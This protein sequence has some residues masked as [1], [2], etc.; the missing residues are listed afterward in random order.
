LPTVGDIAQA[1]KGRYPVLLF[2]VVLVAAFLVSRT[3]QRNR[4]RVS[5]TQAV[6]IAQTE[7]DFRP[8]AHTIRFVQ[9]GVPPR[10][11]WAIRFYIPDPSAQGGYLKATIVW[12]NANTGVVD[13]VIPQR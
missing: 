11:F 9:R 4:V 13:A 8:Q 2:I 7:L 6:A 3:C 1:L 5:S 12:V 10:P